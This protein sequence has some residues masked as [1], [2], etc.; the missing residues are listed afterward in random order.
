MKRLASRVIGR[1]TAGV[2]LYAC[3]DKLE[4]LL[5]SSPSLQARG[6]TSSRTLHPS[7]I[8]RLISKSSVSPSYPHLIMAP[9]HQ[10]TSKPSDA[11][12]RRLSSVASGKRPNVVA[13]TSLTVST[14]AL[15]AD[16]PRFNLDASIISPCGPV[17]QVHQLI[18][19][20]NLRSPFRS[21]IQSTTPTL[22]CPPSRIN[23]T[24]LMFR[25][26]PSRN[27]SFRPSVLSPQSISASSLV[28]V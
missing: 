16:L 11:V 7:Y 14:I 6:V 24:T 21:T 13:Y 23:R 2:S 18:T 10:F 9:P 4:P 26:H 25:L 28:L 19:A 3:K 20:Q 5:S 22:L 17:L 8:N 1:D 12:R 27:M 15:I